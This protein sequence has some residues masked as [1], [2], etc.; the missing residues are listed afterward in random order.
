ML[1]IDTAFVN[2][3]GQWLYCD[4][5]RVAQSDAKEVVVSLSIHRNSEYMLIHAYLGTGKAGLCLVL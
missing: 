1:I 4:D 3:R 2:S 5:S